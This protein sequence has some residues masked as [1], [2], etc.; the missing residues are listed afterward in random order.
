MSTNM[1]RDKRLRKNIS[2]DT[3]AHEEAVASQE[4]EVSRKERGKTPGDSNL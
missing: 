3:E 2:T 4:E 1:S